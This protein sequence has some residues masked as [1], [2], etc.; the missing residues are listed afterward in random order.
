V[1]KKTLVKFSSSPWLPTSLGIPARSLQADDSFE[2][3]VMNGPSCFQDE[4][5]FILVPEDILK[6][7]LGVDGI[8]L[9]S[10]TSLVADENGW[11]VKPTSDGHWLFKRKNLRRA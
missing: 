7:L 4:S 10:E 3:D 6:S 5:D 11:T 8:D 2:T 1:G 9:I